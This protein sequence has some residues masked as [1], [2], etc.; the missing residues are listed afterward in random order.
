MLNQILYSVVTTENPVK[1][2][3]SGMTTEG[4]TTALGTVKEIFS[5]VV[6]TVGENPV[7]MVFFVGGLIPVG[8]RVFK[9]IKNA[10]S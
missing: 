5:W 1:G 4:V 2:G 3:V 10:V 8:I 9:K 6:T 7:L